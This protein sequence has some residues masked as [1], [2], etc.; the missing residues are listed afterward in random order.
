[1][2]KRIYSIAVREGRI[3][4]RNPI[5]LFCMII[6]PIIVVLFFTSMMEEGQPQQ[7]PV[8]VVD[9]DNTAT[10]RA[11]VR[12]L[13]AFQTTKIVRRYAN[14][15][16][17]RGAIQRN[18]I[19]AFIYFPEHTTS[20]LLASRQPKI[21][22]YYNTVFLAAGSLLFRDLKTISMLGSAAVGQARLSALGKTPD[23]IA[24][25]LQPI[26][27][28]L[29]P[30][31]NPT[32]NYN[33]Y[34]STS[35]VPACILL[36]IFL[37]TAYSI[38]TELKF[39]RSRDWIQKAGGNIYIALTGKLLPQFMVFF[40]IMLGFLLYIFYGLD[41]PH[42][43]GLPAI[44][45]L[46]F[47]SVT[48]AQGF[49]IFAFGLMPSLR[50]SMSICSLWAAL[51]FSVMGSTFPVSAMDTEIQ[52]LSWLFPMRHYF[53]FYQ[54]CVFNGFPLTDAW[55]HIGVLIIFACLPLLV[56]HRI[57]RAMLE[58]VYIP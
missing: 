41:F 53:M 35:L 46:A 45:L 48:A 47:L 36:F 34:L 24:T 52:A 16:E 56:V 5:Y 26:A 11:M 39:N 40:A 4:W 33:V 14:M 49:G 37:I 18:E 42:P 21:S 13:D 9:L 27:I 30:L 7:M 25:F 51:S 6:F 44:L 15:N 50:M 38:G 19:Y 32:I 57:R 8:G 10:T 17:A 23:E 55:P 20:D 54:I 28:D 3:L 22:F 31:N 29:H 1:M 12:K 2:F 58:Y 43:G